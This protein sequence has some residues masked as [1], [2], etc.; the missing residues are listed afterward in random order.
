VNRK[1]DFFIVGAPKCGTTA[2]DHFLAAHPDVFM[3]RKE[4]HFFGADLRFAQHFYRRDLPAYLAEFAAADTNRRAGEASVWYL[5]S[6][7]AAEEMKEF[8]P[9]ARIIIMLRNPVEMIHSLFYQFFFDGNEQLAGFEE[10]LAAEEDRRAGRRL[11]RQHYFAQGL[12][13]RE[14]A[15]YT[16]QV[17][18]YFKAFGRDRV[19]VIIYDDFA[20]DADTVFRRA[21][22][23]LGV[24]SHAIQGGSRVIN[25]NKHVKNPI[26]RAV[27]N[28]PSLRRAV[29]ATR[30]LLPQ[31]IFSALGRTEARLRKLNTASAARAAL[32]PELRR[33]LNQEFA[34]EVEQLSALLG[35][36]L[37]GWSRDVLEPK[38]T[39]A[40]A[41]APAPAPASAPAPAP[42]PARPIEECTDRVIGVA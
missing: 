36:D 12:I 29:L 28:D 19:H 42:K 23:F 40:P 1:P 20:A 4:M 22:E 27:L 34:P 10:A 21:L 8:N 38:E 32:S 15:R 3:A 16:R 25:G 5:F 11:G 14:T 37:T 26:L 41:P 13:Y 30:P 7:N 9:D 6:E 24:A 35:R 31:A 18:R 33:R 2:L 17:E 39:A